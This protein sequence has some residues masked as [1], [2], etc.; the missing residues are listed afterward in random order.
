MVDIKALTEQ[1]PD[2]EL[3]TM[4]GFDDCIIG[5]C[6]MIACNPIIAYDMEKV[7]LKNMSN[8]MS[9]EEAEEFFQYNQIGAFMG[10][11]TPCFINKGEE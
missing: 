2:I 9:R 5:V 3:L 10:D 6:E 11:T 7:I 1:Y 4:D 8:G